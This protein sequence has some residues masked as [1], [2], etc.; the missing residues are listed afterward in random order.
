MR[1]G[2]VLWG[3]VVAT[4]TVAAIMLPEPAPAQSSGWVSVATATLD[5]AY[6]NYLGIKKRISTEYNLDASM[7]VSIYP[8]FGTP[9]GG[10]PVWLLAYS[11]SAT[12]RPFTDT[13]IGSGA[14]NVAF[15]AQQFWSAA[16]TG[17]QA[18]SMGLISLPSDW[19]SNN[20]TWS[21]L[22][23]THTLPGAMKWLAVTVGQYN[24]QNLDPNAYAGNPQTNF[25]GYT[26]AQDGTQ[27]FP[28]AGLGAYVQATTPDG[29]FSLAGGFQGA[30]DLAGRQIT[31]R[32]FQTGKYNYWGNIQ[33]NPTVP[34]L[35]S[36]TYSLLVY[37]QPIVPQLPTGSNGISFS[38]SQ[39]INDAWG[40]FVRVSN[41]SGAGALVETSVAFGG[42]R[43]DPFGRNPL[44]Q[45]GL[46]F[47]W[48]KINYAANGVTPASARQSELVAELYY[49]YTIFKGLQITPDVQ[50]FIHP[51]LAPQT[52]AAAVFTVRTTALF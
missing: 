5:E 19:A 28:N 49:N 35:G 46:A 39:A 23:Y 20:Y 13:A 12:W 8:Q 37:R 9:N 14:L 26:F 40:A 38:A 41:A 4:L 15:G 6:D 31:A 27:T 25:I 34:N 43:N 22:T 24:M 7:Q 18:A 10:K 16:T 11:P 47:A 3:A 33:W 30:T 44:D 2:L 36:G 51:A 48:N 45:A 50:I 17:S 29:L 52:N 1:F 21:T 32:G 42:I